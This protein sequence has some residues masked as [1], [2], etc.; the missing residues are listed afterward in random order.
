MHLNYHFLKFLC[1]ELQQELKGYTLLE[2]FSQ[3]KDEL[4]MSFS[5]G[6]RSL[7]LR[8]NLSP[9]NTCLSFPEDYKRSKKNSV[10]LFGDAIGQTVDSIE[11]LP[12][13]RAFQM[14]FVSGKTFLFKLHGNRS[15]ILYYH[16]YQEQPNLI[17]RNELKED[18]NLL[19]DQ[20]KNPLEL[21]FSRFQELNGNAASFLPTLGKIPRSWLKKQGY[22]DSEIDEKWDLM[23][24]LLDMLDAPLYHIVKED[25]NYS[26]SMLPSDHS[27]FT[28]SSAI[29]ASNEYFKY[30][31][32]HQA[33]E[34]EKNGLVK[35]LE[36][37][38][39]KTAAYLKKTREKLEA[40]QNSAS[41]SQ[42]A[43][44]IMANLHQIPEG[45]TEVELF[46]FYQN[47]N[48][49]LQLKKG[50]T[51]QKQA[52]NLYRKSKNRKLELD[53]LNKNLSEKETFNEELDLLLL[54]LESI[55]D[56]KALREFT[57]NQQISR[58]PKKQQENLPFKRFEYDG[59]EVLV[60]KS[61]KANDEMLRHFSWKDDLWLHAKDV[62]GSHV[63]IKFKAGHNI[64][65]SI[66]ERAA[67]LAAF[68]SKNRNESLAPVIYTP[69][70]YVRKVKG[71]APGAVM[72]DKES[73]L[74]VVPKGP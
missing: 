6:N 60:G 69:C 34:K 8:A 59:F 31:I 54:E 23:Q 55:E 58:I 68:Y 35:N 36:E 29:T 63:I 66:I 26:L 3:N 51:P 21:T 43:D 12:F 17:F 40:L 20:L 52:E 53:Q 49:L 14:T 5:E 70:K 71:S 9:A 15:N 4:V 32:V 62:S 7:Y 28:T 74:M 38:K 18:Q 65:K 41:P 33:F 57:K 45:A 30:A 1:P 50:V 37:Q 22:I 11:V 16:A 46:D 19:I 42:T 13:E 48:I 25:D 27:V 10:D 72:V 67:E 73:V 2:C 24:K 64:P 61:A 47:K 39:R 56:F 44:V